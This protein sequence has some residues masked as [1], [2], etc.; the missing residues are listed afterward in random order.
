MGACL[1]R[2][3]GVGFLLAMDPGCPGNK[4]PQP[5]PGSEWCIYGGQSSTTDLCLGFNS[6][7]NLLTC[8][9]D[10]QLELSN[11]FLVVPTLNLAYRQVK[12]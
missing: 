8:L 3:F 6:T 9:I 1:D 7:A 12:Q 2:S 10:Q 11:I 5:W 4:K